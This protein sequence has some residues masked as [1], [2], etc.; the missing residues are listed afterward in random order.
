MKTKNLGVKIL[1]SILPVLFAFLIGGI[2]ISA[3]GGNPFE[4]YKIMITKSLFDMKGITRTL[5][6][7]APLLL[8]AMAISICFKAN[9][10]N[11]GIEGQLVFGGFMAGIVG[12]FIMNMNPFTHKLICFGVGILCGVLFA[13]VPALL[14]AYFRVDEMV[15]TLVLNYAMAKILEYLASVV[16]RDA[17]AGYVAT[18]PVQD[19]ARFFLIG[20][21]KMTPF[22]FVALIVFAVMAFVMTRTKL[23]YTITAL[24]RNP[25]FAEATGLRSRRA[26]MT[27]MLLSGALA[28]IAGTGYMLSEK[29]FYTLDF[30]GSPGLGW[31]GMLIALLGRHTPGGIFA[32][33]LF[34][35]MLKTGSEKIGLY[36]SVPN[37]IV[38]VI[39]GLII[40][41][42]AIQFFDERYGLMERI[43][44]KLNSGKEKQEV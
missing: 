7:A 31:D 15:V 4:T 18:P 17:G 39:Q 40:L 6:L 34:F 28:G 5:Q 26:V 36:T 10:F 16:F 1:N 35:S 27:L 41:F 30:S 43:R 24:G 8:S 44:E 2:I 33:A 38:A 11:M 29:T 22:F 42:L 25:V 3:I 12:H 21:S 9:I 19:S 23:G 37:E 14:R 32:A 20:T 13:V